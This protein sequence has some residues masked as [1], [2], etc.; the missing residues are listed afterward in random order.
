[1][2]APIARGHR[3]QSSSRSRRASLP[4]RPPPQRPV[5]GRKRIVYSSPSL[6]EAVVEHYVGR[7]DQPNPRPFTRLDVAGELGT[8]AESRRLPPHA[9]A[10]PCRARSRARPESRARPGAQ[11]TALHAVRCARHRALPRPRRRPE[12]IRCARF[13]RDV[14]NERRRART[15][16]GGSITGRS[17]RRPETMS[18][19]RPSSCTRTGASARISV[20]ARALPGKRTATAG[21]RRPNGSGTSVHACT[22]HIAVPGHRQRPLTQLLRPPPPMAFT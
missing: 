7:G 3:V 18:A 9:G 15:S 22:G 21:P 1:M 19:P 13:S 16:R 2:R 14:D 17:A 20:G 4:P 6:R 5:G 10:R 8:G 11:T 12:R